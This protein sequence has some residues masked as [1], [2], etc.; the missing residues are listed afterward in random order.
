MF[1]A[2]PCAC[3]AHRRG[4]A[5]QA[6]VQHAVMPGRC[7][8]RQ[9]LAAPLVQLPDRIGLPQLEAQRG[10]VERRGQ[11]LER[12]FEHQP[13]RAQRARQ[14]PRDIVAGHV[15]HHLAAEVHHLAVAVHQLRAQHEVAQRAYRLPARA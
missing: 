1:A 11:H 15:L 4:G 8:Q 13:E 6:H 12:N 9:R 14:Q 3:G 5:C 2:E 7:R 10:F